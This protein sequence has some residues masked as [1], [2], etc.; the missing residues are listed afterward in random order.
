MEALMRRSLDGLQP[1]TEALMQRSVDGLQSS[2][3]SFLKRSM[4][5]FHGLYRFSKSTEARMIMATVLSAVIVRVAYMAWSLRRKKTSQFRRRLALDAKSNERAGGDN[6]DKV[7]FLTAGGDWLSTTS[8]KCRG[9]AGVMGEESESAKNVDGDKDKVMR[10]VSGGIQEPVGSESDGQGLAGAKGE[11]TESVKNVDG[12]KSKA[13]S[14]GVQEPVGSESDGQGLAG[15]KG[16]ETESVKNV[17]EDKS[18]AVSGGAQEPVGSKSDGRGL[19]GAEVEETESAKNVDGDKGKVVSGGVLQP[20]GSEAGGLAVVEGEETES[21]MNVGGDKD[22]VISPVGSESDGQG[23]AGVMG[24]ETKSVKNVG[25]SESGGQGL[26]ASAKIADGDEDKAVCGIQEPAGAEGEETEPTK[27]VDG[28][29]DKVVLV[30]SGGLPE[31][32]AGAELEVTKSGDENQLMLQVFGGVEA[33]VSV[34]MDENV[35][36]DGKDKMV[37]KG[38]DGKD[39]AADGKDK[40]VDGKDQGFMAG[41]QQNT[42]VDEDATKDDPDRNQYTKED[43]ALIYAAKRKGQ[44]S[45]NISGN[46]ICRFLKNIEIDEELPEELCTKLV[47][48]G[49]TNGPRKLMLALPAY[50]SYVLRQLEAS[51]PKSLEQA[52]GFLNEHFVINASKF[53]C[54][55]G[56]SIE[57]I[58]NKAKN[59]TFECVENSAVEVARVL[60]ESFERS[61]KTLADAIAKT[62]EDYKQNLDKALTNT[63]VAMAS[64]NEAL[65][66]TKEALAVARETQEAMKT[67]EEALQ[68]K[69]EALK[70]KDV[71]LMQALEANRQL[72]EALYIKECNTPAPTPTKSRPKTPASTR[73]KSRANSSAPTSTKS[74][75]KGASSTTRNTRPVPP[76]NSRVFEVT[77]CTLPFNKAKESGTNTDNSNSTMTDAGAGDP[78]C[79]YCRKSKSGVCVRHK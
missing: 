48:V 19:A 29:K 67:K 56:V 50:D 65:A 70:E 52:K 54:R 74:R 14:G 16:E 35:S 63:Q 1:S 72:A 69:D 42:P 37:D 76:T 73:T 8:V 12:D 39:K 22:K 3:E 36:I 5:G 17:D 43:I 41:D 61:T 27:N 58:V 15:A 55:H 68:K 60:S 66:N 57:R 32:P 24:E 26:A 79:Q 46:R 28:D 75:A 31:E 7:P 30:V 33:P 45:V 10:L 77:P 2:M 62:S 64:T 44:V 53:Y 47:Y 6:K 18:K 4:D 71:E 21:A 13:A 51:M 40:G 34:E 20:T 59:S 25:G 78:N 23:L 49:K 38:V 9:L 11:E